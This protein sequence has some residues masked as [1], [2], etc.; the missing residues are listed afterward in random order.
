MHIRADFIYRNWSPRTQGLIDAVLYIVLYFPGLLVFLYMASDYA[1]LA[2]IRGEKGMDTAWM[3]HM[4]PIK[5]ALPLGVL[6]LLI[7]GF[8]ELLKSIYAAQKGRWP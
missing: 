3:P 6:F 1:S 7:Q 5:T 8:S 2:W 4:G